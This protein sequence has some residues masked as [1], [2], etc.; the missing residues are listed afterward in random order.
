MHEANV[1]A[2]DL[3]ERLRGLL[4]AGDRVADHERAPAVDQCVLEDGDERVRVVTGLGI[5]HAFYDGDARNT[6]GPMLRQ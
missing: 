5:D 6:R 1:A 3:V 2:E 4:C